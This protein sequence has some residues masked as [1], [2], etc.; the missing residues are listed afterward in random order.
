[1]AKNQNAMPLFP[2]T[3]VENSR[4]RLNFAMLLINVQAVCVGMALCYVKVTGF[5]RPQKVD[6]FTV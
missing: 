2:S 6:D 3:T 4:A 5:I 1:M